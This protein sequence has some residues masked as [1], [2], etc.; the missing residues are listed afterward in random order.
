MRTH[1]LVPIVL[2]AAVLGSTGCSALIPDSM[3]VDAMVE[4]NEDIWNKKNLDRIDELF[5]EELAAETRAF[6]EPKLAEDPDLHLDVREVLIDG[7]RG[8]ARWTITGTHSEYGK[9]VSVDEM[10]LNRRDGMKVVEQEIYWDRLDEARQRGLAVP[11][12]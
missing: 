4:A 2:A 10:T 9:K 7:D 5:S 11:D 3:I 1:R 12:F 6:A 8:A